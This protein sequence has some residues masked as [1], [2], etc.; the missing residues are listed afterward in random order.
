MTSFFLHFMENDNLGMIAT[1]HQI[2][3]DQSP[4]GTFD[5]QC[6]R[7]AALHSTAVDYSKT[8]IAVGHV[9]DRQKPTIDNDSVQV[10]I[11]ELPKYPKCRPDFQA[12]G[13]QVL[14]ED[15]AVLLEQQDV[16][17]P[18]DGD[19]EFDEV[20]AYGPQRHRYYASEKVLG[21]LYRNIDE[22]QFF[23]KIKAQSGSRSSENRSV[24]PGVWKYVEEKTRL[25]QWRHYTDFALNVMEK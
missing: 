9:T 16:E 5:P 24:I 12:P 23:A 10:S 4:F 19:D 15:K 8:G 14:I 3:A 13:P 17:T 7:L 2:L 20:A 11:T 22:H 1:L 21:K 6:V 25:I 18:P